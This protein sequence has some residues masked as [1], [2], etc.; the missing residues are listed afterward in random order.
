MKTTPFLG[1]RRHPLPPLLLPPPP[2]SRYSQSPVARGASDDDTAGVIFTLDHDLETPV[3]TLSSPHV[4]FLYTLLPPPLEPDL[5]PTHPP[6]SL[7]PS[8]Q[9]HLVCR[10]EIVYS[11][12]AEFPHLLHSTACMNVVRCRG[13]GPIHLF[14]ASV[15]CD[16][17]PLLMTLSPR[18]PL[19][20]HPPPL[21]PSPTSRPL[22]FLAL[23]TSHPHHHHHHHHQPHLPVLQTPSLFSR[24]I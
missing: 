18:P 19:S 2:P 16:L 5:P 21:L 6:T 22:F 10:Q 9:P 23:L 1:L 11:L 20:L 17:P 12:S 15:L 14:A 7:H 3:L 13:S 24:G 8:P 4:A